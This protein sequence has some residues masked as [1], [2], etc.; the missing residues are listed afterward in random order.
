MVLNQKDNGHRKQRPGE[1]KKRAAP[2]IPGAARST[3]AAGV[4]E[5]GAAAVIA[6]AWEAEGVRRRGAG[7]DV[8]GADA[9]A[10]EAICQADPEGE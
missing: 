3:Q 7:G 6:Q 5:A 2:R 10:P 8:A 4:S 1:V 9:G